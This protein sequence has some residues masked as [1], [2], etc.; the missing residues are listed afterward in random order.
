MYKLSDR[1]PNASLYEFYNILQRDQTGE[2][3][4]EWLDKCGNRYSSEE[5][6]STIKH[7]GRDDLA[8]YFIDYSA[9]EIG[10]TIKSRYTSRIGT[11]DGI[12]ADGETL[13]VKWKTGGRQLIT[14]ASV[15]IV[16]KKDFKTYSDVSK[17]ECDEKTYED[18][19]KFLEKHDK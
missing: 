18:I 17:P 16:N 14:K 19:D 1:D 11:V 5:I 15:F 3:I 4:A 10:D 8:Q 7:A 12:H 9:I 6:L 13:E 2:K